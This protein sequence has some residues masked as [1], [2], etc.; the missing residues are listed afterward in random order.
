MIPFCIPGK[1]LIVAV[2][3][4][5]GEELTNAARQAG[6]PGATIMMGRSACESKIMQM[7]ALGD[8]R[9][10]IA[11][12]LTGDETDS[13]VDAIKSAAAQSPKKLQGTALLLDV[14]GILKQS[15]NAIQPQ[16][17]QEQKKENPPMKS[18]Y[19][20]VTVIINHGYADDV[21][22]AARHA[23]A[24]GGTILIARGTGTEADSQFFGITLVPE[25][26]VLLIL[27]ENDKRD[28]ILAVIKGIPVLSEPGSGIVFTMDVMQFINLGESNSNFSGI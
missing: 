7:L 26:E 15:F 11:L 13:I 18:E 16:Q 28:A 22:A 3:R 20:L 12:I 10:D 5:H 17:G 1:L 24:V 9:R 23:G 14:A 27:T 6:A 19:T 4:H 21:M 8:M 2:G 25:K